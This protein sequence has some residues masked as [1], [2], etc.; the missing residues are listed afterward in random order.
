MTETG[1][2]R[3]FD[4]DMVIRYIEKIVVKKDQ[5]EFHMKTG[6]TLETERKH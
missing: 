2:I 6:I 4:N 5:I 3:R 1:Y